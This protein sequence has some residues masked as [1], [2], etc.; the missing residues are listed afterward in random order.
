MY[1]HSTPL[2]VVQFIQVSLPTTPNLVTNGKYVLQ[3]P[4]IV[5]TSANCGMVCLHK[6]TVAKQNYYICLHK[7]TPTLGQHTHCVLPLLQ[8]IMCL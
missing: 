6:W 5:V 2:W 4:T 3:Q 7:E 8:Q 1:V